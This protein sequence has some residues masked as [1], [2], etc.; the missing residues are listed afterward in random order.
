MDFDVVIV[1]GGPAGLTAGIYC[2]RRDLEAVVVERNLPGGNMQ[3]AAEI[4]NWPGNKHVSGAE[5][6][7]RMA[8][9]AKSLGVEFIYNEVIAL[10][11]RGDVKS[12]T[13]RDRELTCSAIILATGGKVAKLKVKGEEEY[14]GKGVSYCATCDG[15]FF[16]DKAVAVV[17]AGNMAVEDALYIRE[18]ASKT[19]L[20]AKEVKA[21]KSLMEKLESSSVEVIADS[22]TEI[23][24]ADFVE[25]VKLS[26]GKELQVGGVFICGGHTASSELAKQAGV[27]LDEKGSI[28]VDRDMRTNI[29]GVFAAGDVTGGIPQITVAAGE[30]CIAALTAY[31]H[32]KS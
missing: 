29:P 23:S 7:E 27:E 10:G 31:G 13:L 12:V 9:H 24:G 21:D 17:G 2:V 11:L 1:G 15:P 30:G 22:L 16:K 25:S 5:L 19:Y 18:L 28:R 26:S 20:V 6:S 3:Q 4:E 32:V 14:S 8:G